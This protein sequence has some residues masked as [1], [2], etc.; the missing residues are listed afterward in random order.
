MRHSILPLLAFFAGYFLSGLLTASG[1]MCLTSSALI[2]WDLV[3][4]RVVDKINVVTT[5]ICVVIFFVSLLTN[6]IDLIKMK[7]TIVHCLMASVLLVSLFLR[8]NVLQTIM[9]KSIKISDEAWA[10]LAKRYIVFLLGV[11]V[12]NELVWRCF[13]DNVW[14]AF[15]VFGIM[16]A[17]MLFL[18]AQVPLIKRSGNTSPYHHY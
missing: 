17:N 8:R 9:G 4:G 1:A 15:K 5:C 14:I 10:R 13:N 6:D 12:L 18:I 7:P 2:A 16:V 3:H 11:A